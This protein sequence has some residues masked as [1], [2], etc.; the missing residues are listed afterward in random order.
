M[1][2]NDGRLPKAD[3]VTLHDVAREAG[4]HPSTVS[5]ALDP[6]RQSKVKESTRRR[7]AEVASRLGYRP[8]MVARWLQSG[9][10]ATVGIVAADLGNTFVTPII[11]GIA[12]AI[13]G[14]GMLAMIA[15]TQDDHD[16]F[17]TILD[18]MLSRRVDAIVAVAARAGDKEILEAAGRLVPVVIAG[19]P[20]DATVLAQVVHDDRLGGAMV[21]E[22]LHGLG[23]RLVAQ[24][25]GPDDVANFPRRAEG[26]STFCTTAGMV[27]IPLTG[28]ADRPTISE[29][30]RL[31]EALIGAGGELP[32]AIFAHNDLIALGA[33]AVIRAAGLEV[34][35]AVSLVGYN[36]LPMVGHLSPPLTTIR[37][38][39]LEVGKA[40]GDMILDLLAGEEP[41]DVSMAPALVVRS[42]TRHI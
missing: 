36:D 5:R 9:R 1:G 24:L 27:E 17:S 15:E 14:A 26:F 25:R 37:Y 7:I 30:Q 8:H 22:H 41:E 16:R 39:S 20:L 21:A 19:R 29:G 10:T 28:R 38:P 42:S 33:L 2:A 34:P 3:S 31:M 35:G 4:V 32:T 40:A 13:E 11:H 18:H 23:H 12:G 6:A